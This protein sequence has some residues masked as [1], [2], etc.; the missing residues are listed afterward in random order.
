LQ[1]SPFQ[2]PVSIGKGFGKT[3][4]KANFSDKSK[5]DF[6]KAGVLEEAQ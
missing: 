1:W 2:N 3:V 6:P 5:V 4:P